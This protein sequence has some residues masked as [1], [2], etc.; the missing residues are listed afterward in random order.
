MFFVR[1]LFVDTGSAGVFALT[2]LV[3]SRAGQ[4]K[5][6][7]GSTAIVSMDVANSL[8]GQRSTTWERP[9]LE[10]LPRTATGKVIRRELEAL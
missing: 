10:A 5:R 6:L 8:W 1:W 4:R 9:F 7:D 3:E 2:R